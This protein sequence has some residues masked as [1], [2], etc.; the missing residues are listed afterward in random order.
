MESNAYWLMGGKQG[1]PCNIACGGYFSLG[2]L[3]S[4]GKKCSSVPQ[5]VAWTPGERVEVR[6]Q[7]L[8]YRFC[9]LLG[10]AGIPEPPGTR[11]QVISPCL[12]LGE[13]SCGDNPGA[14]VPAGSCLS[15]V[16]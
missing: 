10:P 12:C 14:Q 13:S 11:S 5:G 4:R 15:D 6:P 2:H 9:L 1:S 8:E 16:S 3:S 7:G